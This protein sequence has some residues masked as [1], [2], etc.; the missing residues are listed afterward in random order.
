LPAKNLLFRL[1]NRLD[2]STR[3][4]FPKGVRDLTG[5][6]FTTTLGVVVTTN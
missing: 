1:D 5:Q 6:L 4:I 2:S 3:E